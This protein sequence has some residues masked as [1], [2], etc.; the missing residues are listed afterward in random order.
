[1]QVLWHDRFKETLLIDGDHPLS[2][3]YRLYVI[4]NDPEM[5]KRYRAKRKTFDLFAKQVDHAPG[6]F[7]SWTQNRSDVLF[8]NR[9]E[10]HKQVSKSRLIGLVVHEV[11]HLVDAMFERAGIKR[12]D[13]E[14]RSYTMDWIVEKYFQMYEYNDE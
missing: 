6:F 13:T 4:T 3:G 8:I 11:S 9:F 14:L 5:P 10:G 1:M 7:A 12:V 2:L